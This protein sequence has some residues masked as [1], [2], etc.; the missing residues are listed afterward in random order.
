MR[1]QGTN[2]SLHEYLTIYDV[3]F[4]EEGSEQ[5]YNTCFAM[6]TERRH[7]KDDAFYME[8]MDSCKDAVRQAIK[9]GMATT[10][11]AGGIEQAEELL[12]L[13]AKN[14]STIVQEVYGS[15]TVTYAA[16]VF[17]MPKDI[18]PLIT[19]YPT[20][21][22]NFVMRFRNDDE[23]ID[24]AYYIFFSVQAQN[25]RDTIACYNRWL[26]CYQSFKPA[27][28]GGKEVFEK[29]KSIAEQA[30]DSKISLTE[31]S[32]MIAETVYCDVEASMQEVMGKRFANSMSA[33]MKYEFSFPQ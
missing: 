1:K 5:K 9:N 22:L 17:L 21:K 8:C 11:A 30:A 28:R 18:K 23:S 24:D 27:A 32:D 12:A 26:E 13:V 20:S 15:Q 3:T 31:A 19:A 25:R 4:V 29:V 10:V 6:K 14:I 33:D 2:K 16:P 7:D